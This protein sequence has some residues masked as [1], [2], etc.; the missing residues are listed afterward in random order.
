MEQTETLA[1]RVLNLRRYP[2]RRSVPLVDD[3]Q[4]DGVVA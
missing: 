4:Q 2:K 3:T 1:V